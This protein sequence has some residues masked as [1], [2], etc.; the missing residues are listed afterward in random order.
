MIGERSNHD[1]YHNY[2]DNPNE[3]KICL[4]H[5][6]ANPKAKHIIADRR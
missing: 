3:F 6:P 2:R 1:Y 4:P 5:Q